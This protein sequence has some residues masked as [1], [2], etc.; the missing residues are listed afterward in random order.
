MIHWQADPAEWRGSL[1][2]SIYPGGRYAVVMD[3]RP[4][5]SGTGYTPGPFHDTTAQ[6]ADVLAFASHATGD[7][8][9][10][11]G[12]GRPFADDLAAMADDIERGA[13]A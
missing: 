11:A 1:S 5:F 3:G 2:V 6:V 9:T 4:V 13:T 10:L 8:R 7:G 12:A